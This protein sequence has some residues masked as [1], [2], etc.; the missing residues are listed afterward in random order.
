MIYEVWAYGQYCLPKV[1]NGFKTTVPW[2]VLSVKVQ[3]WPRQT[4]KHTVSGC[5]IKVTT[6]CTFYMSGWTH[7]GPTSPDAQFKG[8]VGFQLDSCVVIDS[9]VVLFFSFFL[10]SSGL[11]G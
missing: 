10:L 3:R 6:I 1:S 4:V 11:D 2:Y 7:V 5:Y 8:H 9:L